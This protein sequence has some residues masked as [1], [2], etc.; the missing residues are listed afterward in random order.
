MRPRVAV[1][2]LEAGILVYKSRV[3][4]SSRSETEGFQCLLSIWIG[5]M[6]R[7]LIIL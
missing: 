4:A 6:F 7:V 2:D 1:K 3:R 5:L